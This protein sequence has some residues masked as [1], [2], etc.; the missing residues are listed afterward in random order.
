MTEIDFD[1]LD[2][3]E[4][5]AK[6][7]RA[8]RFPNLS[9]RYV[10]GEGGNA[11]AFIIGEAPG[12]DEDMK[13]RPFVGPAGKVMRQ[14]M[15]LAHLYA[16]REIVSN[17]WL[18]N[19]LKFRPPKNRKPLPTEVSA[20]RKLLLT[21]WQAV[22]AP[23]L[24]IPV[25]GSALHA[26]IG[27]RQSILR[28]A[29]KPHHYKRHPESNKPNMVIWPMVH[30]SFGMRAGRDVQELLEQDWERLGEWRAKNL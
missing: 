9:Q 25:G 30:P 27:K 6:R 3:I 20:F 22:G 23:R 8:N 28:A 21:E 18:T 17:C 13:R 10:P 29:G 2:E 14:L 24:V 12:A 4:R 15:A 16:G 19:T 5:R 7:I 26:V 11:E 1:T